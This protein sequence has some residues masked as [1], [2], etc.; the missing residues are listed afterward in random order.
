[1]KVMLIMVM[2]MDDDDNGDSD[3]DG[4]GNDWDNEND[5]DHEDD[6]ESELINKSLM[7]Y[8]FTISTIR[9]HK[10]AMQCKGMNDENDDDF[11][12]SVLSSCIVVLKGRKI[13]WKQI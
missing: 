11:P 12:S 1:M 6:D 3:G 7:Q 13:W 4:D 9:R 10:T 8:A 2:V 5:C